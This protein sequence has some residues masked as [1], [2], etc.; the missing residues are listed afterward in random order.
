MCQESSLAR[1]LQIG[2]KLEKWQDV[3]ISKHEIISFFDITLFLL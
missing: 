2:H 3:T 1:L